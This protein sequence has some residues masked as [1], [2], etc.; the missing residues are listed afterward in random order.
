M[1]LTIRLLL[2]SLY[3]VNEAVQFSFFLF[4]ENFGGHNLFYPS[5][6]LI[7]LAI[8]HFFVFFVNSFDWL[9]LRLQLSNF[10]DQLINFG[11]KSL[12]LAAF[13]SYLFVG[14]LDVELEDK[15]TFTCQR[16]MIFIGVNFLIVL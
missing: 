11:L 3:L 13:S 12:D 7:Q 9:C 6:L 1:N 8:A 4:A 10:C 14:P 16:N 15:D 5:F 2:D